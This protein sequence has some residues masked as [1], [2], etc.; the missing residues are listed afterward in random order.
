M[1]A[2][3]I[4]YPPSRPSR[5]SRPHLPP[6]S[7]FRHKSARLR[8]LPPLP[9]R[10]PPKPKSG[11]RPPP[12]M[13]DERELRRPPPP[14]PQKYPS[15]KYPSTK[16]P[17]SRR[18]P[19]YPSPASAVGRKLPQQPLFRE[20]FQNSRYRGRPG[21]KDSG[22]I[23]LAKRMPSKKASK[24]PSPTKSSE[25]SR[26]EPDDFPKFPSAAALPS[27]APTTAS[28]PFSSTFEPPSF[29]PPTFE[30]PKDFGS[31]ENDA[32]DFGFGPPEGM[33]HDF[34][35]FKNPSDK[36]KGFDNPFRHEEADDFPLQSFEGPPRVKPKFQKAPTYP[37]P[38]QKR[39]P[40]DLDVNLGIPPPP[41][42]HRPK[43][44]PHG[45]PP[46]S[47]PGRPKRYP[48][49][50]KP[51]PNKYPKQQPTP[52][53]ANYRPK[54]DFL[55]PDGVFDEDTEAEFKLF[56]DDGS[57]IKSGPPVDFEFEASA[58]PGKGRRPHRPPPSP[59]RP[60]HPPPPPPKAGRRPRPPPPP[61]RP[62]FTT[63]RPIPTPGPEDFPSPPPRDLIQYVSGVIP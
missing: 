18:G 22:A 15:T 39:Y 7:S 41:P 19:L 45:A 56:G 31:S 60:H 36:F 9:K 10:L 54:N 51:R 30:S 48:P 34:N 62:R 28:K 23:D 47:L 57:P 16:F 4:P 63:Q 61:S 11:R 55:S 1:S 13:Y 2:M 44:P 42:P 52:F 58:E 32:K 43:R 50:F 6:Q 14:L 27:I 59:H 20:D 53:K 12:M 25:N 46:P 29:D 35:G 8:P 37:P 40:V 26:M 33:D 17:T 21:P 38:P 24:E 49:S 3:N 5:Q